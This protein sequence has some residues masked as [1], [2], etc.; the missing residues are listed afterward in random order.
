L[1]YINFIS[2][3][4]KSLYIFIK[5]T[6]I[7][8]CKCFGVCKCIYYIFLMTIPSC[9]SILISCECIPKLNFIFCKGTL[10]WIL[11]TKKMIFWYSLNIKVLQYKLIVVLFQEISWMH[12]LSQLI[13]WVQIL[14]LLFLWILLNNKSSFLK[15]L[16]TYCTY[17]NSYLL[18]QLV[19][20]HPKAKMFWWFFLFF[21]WQWAIWLVYHKNIMKPPAPLHK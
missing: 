10:W 13:V 1:S 7:A 17:C 9:K 2:I 16:G 20:M 15:S 21:G 6:Y 11:H 5:Y 19:V 12:I 14:L 3:Y 8:P 4:M 18:I